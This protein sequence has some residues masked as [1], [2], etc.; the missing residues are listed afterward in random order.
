MCQIF[1]STFTS[2]V[3]VRI[4]IVCILHILISEYNNHIMHHILNYIQLYFS[5]AILKIIK[6]SFD[7]SILTY[8]N[9]DENVL[10]EI[11]G[12]RCISIQP[13]CK[14][15]NIITDSY[16]KTLHLYFMYIHITINIIFHLTARC[17]G[18]DKLI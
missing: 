3:Y 13:D 1:K 17:V 10:F 11:K 6:N 14:Q 2:I 8:R 12:Y 9:V 16:P 5:V 4:I 7:L 15:V 18:H